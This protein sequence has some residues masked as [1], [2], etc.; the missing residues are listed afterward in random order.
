LLG[1][2]KRAPADLQYEL[3]EINGRAGLLVRQDQ[4]PVLIMMA[5]V[6]EGKIAAIWSMRNPDKLRRL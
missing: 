1:L 3:T 5:D 6:V 2:F 4:V